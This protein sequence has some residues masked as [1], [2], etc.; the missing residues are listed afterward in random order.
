MCWFYYISFSAWFIKNLLFEHK[1]IR[2]WNKRHF[3]DTWNTNYAA[4]L[5]NAVNSVVTSANKVNIGGCCP[6]VLCISGSFKGWY[7]APYIIVQSVKR[8][9]GSRI[10]V[11]VRYFSVPQIPQPEPG[12]RGSFP[13]VKR[14][15]YE[16]NHSSPYSVQDKNEW[17]HTSTPPIC[18]PGVDSKSMLFD[19]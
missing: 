10:R 5:K 4:C 16:F 2:L 19:H 17:S 15:G 1:R 7:T 14:S 8:P 3:V 11:V 6:A 13:G 9:S 12:Y 18:I